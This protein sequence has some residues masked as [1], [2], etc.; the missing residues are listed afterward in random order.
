MTRIRDHGTRNAPSPTYAA[1]KADSSSN[2]PLCIRKPNEVLHPF[3]VRSVIATRERSKRLMPLITY[4][5]PQAWVQSERDSSSRWVNSESRSTCYLTPTP[6]AQ[7]A[8]TPPLPAVSEPHTGE[9]IFA[10]DEDELAADTSHF[11]DCRSRW[12]HIYIPDKVPL[13]GRINASTRL[14]RI[15]K[16]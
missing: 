5:N 12:R 3:F 2:G 10:I 6:S 4:G 9:I 13:F 16:D 14:H 8:R 11:L 7:A 15:Y 1:V